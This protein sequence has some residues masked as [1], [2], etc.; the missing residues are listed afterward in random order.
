MKK[1]KKV[2]EVVAQLRTVKRG[3]RIKET[4]LGQRKMKRGEFKLAKKKKRGTSCEMNKYGKKK[5]ENRVRGPR[6]YV[7]IGEVYPT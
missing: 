5:V 7:L 3:K 6:P 4:V 1:K 2:T